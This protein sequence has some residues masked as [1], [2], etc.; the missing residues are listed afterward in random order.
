MVAHLT[1]QEP[2]LAVYYHQASQGFTS[3]GLPPN[4]A[5]CQ[6]PDLE[7][8]YGGAVDGAREMFARLFP[9]HEFLP[10]AAR[11]EDDDDDDL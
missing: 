11:A 7:V 6:P 3:D 2:L 10:A 4:V 9:G 5:L 1:P 8:G